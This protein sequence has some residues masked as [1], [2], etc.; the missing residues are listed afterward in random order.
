[1]KI[2]CLIGAAL[3]ALVLGSTANAA[4]PSCKPTTHRVST[5]PP[6]Y[7]RPKLEAGGLRLYSRAR[8]RDGLLVF[9]ARSGSGETRRIRM[10]LEAESLSDAVMSAAWLRGDLLGAR[11]EML[12]ELNAC[13]KGWRA[14]Y[15]GSSSFGRWLLVTFEARRR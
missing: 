8:D 6:A 15:V 4:T 11:T 2:V 14:R 5:A 10:A 1:V 7:L 13:A 9:A 12:D 3:V